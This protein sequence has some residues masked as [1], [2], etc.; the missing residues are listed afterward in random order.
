[1]KNL[2]ALIRFLCLLLIG[3]GI[4]STHADNLPDI[5]SQEPSYSGNDLT[6]GDSICLPGQ[7]PHYL[8]IYNSN[9]KN[10]AITTNNGNGNLRIYARQES[11]PLLDGSDYISARGG[12]SQCIIINNPKSG[13]VYITV[14]GSYANASLVVDFDRQTCREIFNQD[15]PGVSGLYAVLKLLSSIFFAI[16]EALYEIAHPI[17]QFFERI[18]LNLD[19]IAETI[20]RPDLPDGNNTGSGNNDGGNNGGGNNGG[21]NNGG[22]N[23]DHRTNGYPFESAH[24]LVYPVHFSNSQ[25]DWPN[26]ED[27]LRQVKEYYHRQSYGRFN[28]TWEMKQET[29]L[30]ED[31]RNLGF[32]EWVEHNKDIV[33][34]SGESWPP[35][36]NKLVLFV[37][38]FLGP[39]LGWN[40]TGGN[41][42]MRIFD[43]HKG[44]GVIAHEMGH[45]M[46]LR[47]AN[48]IE[49]NSYTAIDSR[50]PGH[51]SR[52]ERR[53]FLI[54]YGSRSSMM[55]GGAHSLEEYNL[56]YKSFYKNWLDKDR[57]VPLITHSGTYRIYS[58]DHSVKGQGN[59]GL[60][61]KS[62]NDKYTY[63]L[64][65]RT[66]GRNFEDDSKNGILVNIEGYHET[67]TDPEFWKTTTYL[68]DMTPGSKSYNPGSTNDL[69]DGAL[70]LNQSYTDH[71]GKFRI[72]PVRKG[73]NQHSAYAWIEVRVEILK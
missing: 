50:N 53:N 64:E 11:W 62:G 7:D 24:I 69:D 1:M 16:A 5:C 13:W 2:P 10:I 35:G 30:Y 8:S 31:S 38:P 39:G 12:N 19:H 59:I 4:E 72:T 45:A 48:G 20:N 73:G 42:V 37:R 34:N 29:Y 18:A 54:E 41:K 61:L 28:V 3:I 22:E 43:G 14:K 52:E 44:P 49:T 57:D 26:L 17:A 25:L 65:Y 46:G 63:W 71:W 70:L 55:G 9:A 40:S 36:G 15:N 33:K 68:L 56:I 27:D 58:F 32:H 60:R 47:H 6:N 67:E 23:T 66:R 21:G 51:M